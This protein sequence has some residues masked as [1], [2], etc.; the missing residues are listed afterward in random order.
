[1]HGLKLVERLMDPATRPTLEQEIGALLAGALLEQDSVDAPVASGAP[2]EESAAP[3]K[4]AVRRDLPAP[5][6]PDLERHAVTLDLD[7]VWEYL[8][9][10][11][12]YGKHLGLRGVVKKLAEEGDPKSLKL[13]RRGRGAEGGR[14]PRRHAGEGGLAVLPGALRGQSADSPRSEDRRR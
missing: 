13:A 14:A 10:Q 9:P 1:M 3:R 6:P 5:P 2:I 11:M 8:N 12:L 7:A 4:S